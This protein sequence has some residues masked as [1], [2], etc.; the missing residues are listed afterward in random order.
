M[1]TEEQKYSSVNNAAQEIEKM[2]RGGPLSNPTG[3][4]ETP[5][6]A[7]IPPPASLQQSFPSTSSPALAQ[8]PYMTTAPPQLPAA[9]KPFMVFVNMPMLPPEFGLVQKITGPGEKVINSFKRHV[10]YKSCD[11]LF[12]IHLLT[13]GL[14]W[15]GHSRR[16]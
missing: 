2:I 11:S 13:F 15:I 4:P 12:P 16:S 3:P 5:H 8:S 10:V 9:P 7:A 1:Q 6:Y 14:S